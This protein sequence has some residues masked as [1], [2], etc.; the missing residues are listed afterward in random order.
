MRCLYHFS[1]SSLVRSIA[2]ALAI[3]SVQY[4]ANAQTPSSR[5][6]I[7]GRYDAN[8]II[9]YFEAVQFNGTLPTN[10]Q[11]LVPAAKFFFDSIE[12][13]TDFIAPFSEGSQCGTIWPR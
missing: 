7:A 8:R 6:W 5:V 11:K 9:V 12:V 3:S 1:D 10:A 4:Q 2:L 13:S